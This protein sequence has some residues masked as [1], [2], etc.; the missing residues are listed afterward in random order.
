MTFTGMLSTDVTH[1]LVLN[2]AYALSLPKAGQKGWLSFVATAGETVAI[3]ITS[4]STTPTSN[5]VYLYVY[6]PSGAT[7]ASAST[8]TSY[9]FNLS[10]LVAGTYTLFVDPQYAATATM[11]VEVVP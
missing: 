2:T 3:E 5:T 9:T 10:N 6:D 7:L 11:T 1:T 4:V 8:T